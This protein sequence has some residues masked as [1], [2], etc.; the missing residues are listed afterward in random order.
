MVIYNSNGEVVNR[1][2]GTTEWTVAE[3]P[4]H[5][6]CWKSMKFFGTLDQK[7]GWIL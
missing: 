6:V 2:V 5:V 3:D 7:S 1:E 4:N